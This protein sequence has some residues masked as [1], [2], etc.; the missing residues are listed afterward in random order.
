MVDICE[1]PMDDDEDADCPI[2]LATLSF[3]ALRTHLATHLEELALFVLPCHMEDRSQDAGFDKVE[4]APGQRLASN[5]SGSEDGLPPLDFEK[6]LPD[7]SHSQDPEIF[8]AL[9]QSTMEVEHKDMEDWILTNDQT[10]KPDNVDSILPIAKGYMDQIL[11]DRAKEFERNVMEMGRVEQLQQAIPHPIPPPP[12][13]EDMARFQSIK[14]EE[15]T[16][17][18]APPDHLPMDQDIRQA[19]VNKLLYI[20]SKLSNVSKV[21]PRWFTITHDEDRLRVFFRTLLKVAYQFEDQSMQ[22]PKLRLSMELEDIYE[23]LIVAQGM[24]ADVLVKYP[25]LPRSQVDEGVLAAKIESVAR[26]WLAARPS[27]ELYAVE[28][29]AKVGFIGKIHK[30]SV[31]EFEATSER[32]QNESDSPTRTMVDEELNGGNDWAGIEKEGEG[33]HPDNKRYEY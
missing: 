31:K 24:I 21:A 27:S 25:S 9:L 8:S 30:E 22:T 33:V 7:T 28:H 5:A 4:G 15:R 11:W 26:T 14:Q 16:K 29:N 18:N 3:S 10:E 2:C 12:T 23:A 20:A 6:S 19:I 32:I 17:F 1:R 13:P